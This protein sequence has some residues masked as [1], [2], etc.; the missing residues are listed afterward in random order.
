VEAFRLDR[1]EAFLLGVQ[2]HPEW[3]FR[4]DPLSVVIFRSF[5]LAARARQAAK[6]AAR[7]ADP[8]A[9]TPAMPHPASR[10]AA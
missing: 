4:D 2:W 8:Q 3:A 7:Q 1:A 6:Q 9:M 10:Q 5:G